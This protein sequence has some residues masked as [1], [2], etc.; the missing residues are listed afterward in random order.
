MDQGATDEL[1]PDLPHWHRMKK[2][3]FNEQVPRLRVD[4][5]NAQ[6]EMKERKDFSAVIAVAGDDWLGVNG[7]LNRLNEWMDARLMPTYVFRTPSDEEAARPYTW[8]LWRHLPGR[9]EMVLYAGAAVQ[10]IV[11][12]AG[13]VGLSGVLTLNVLERRRDIGVMRAIGASTWRVVRL[14]V[15]EGMLL[16]WL[17]WM[18]A[19]PL[20][21][22]L[23]YFVATQALS[24]ALT[25]QLAYRFTPAGALVWL[26]VITLLA[27]FASLLP[28]RSAA[29]V[30]VRESLS[31]S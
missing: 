4:L 7:V 25:Q 17:S 13:G 14:Y 16:G 20:S 8:R 27:I 12:V 24:F 5:V 30:S 22:P 2:K 6:Y 3:E 26:V 28:A 11:A 1:M 18:I 10:E 15:G 29:R 19:L 21:I 23:A 31:Y 9:G